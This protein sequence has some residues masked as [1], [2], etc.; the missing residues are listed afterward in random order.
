MKKVMIALLALAV[1]FSFAACDNSSGTPDSTSKEIARIYQAAT[2]DV[3][4]LVGQVA[5][6]DDF[7]VMVEYTD[8]TSER[9]ASSNLT[10]AVDGTAADTQLK[11]DSTLAVSYNL[12]PAGAQAT[13][14]LSVTILPV[15]S[16]KVVFNGGSYDSYYEK[17][18]GSV[19]YNGSDATTANDIFH[20]SQYTV[21]AVYDTDKEYVLSSDEYVVTALT[22]T[23]ANVAN[24]TATIKL[25]LNKDGKAD[26]NES[27][28]PYNTVS[29]TAG[30][31][32]ILA[33]TLSGINATL[34]EGKELIAGAVA[35]S[36]DVKGL[37]TVTGN[38]A[39]G[40]VKALSTEVTAVAFD[41][42]NFTQTSTEKD[43][44]PTT[45][46]VK[47]NFTVT[48]LASVQT[49][50]FPVIA[51]YVKSFTVTP[52]GGV[53]AG[54]SITNALTVK[55]TWAASKTSDKS[56]ETKLTIVASPS[57]MPSTTVVGSKIPV[58]VSIQ[59]QDVA[60][61][62]IFVE[63]VAASAGQGAGGEEA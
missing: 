45:G 11:A 20:K 28:E 62:T 25:D 23:T 9:V 35:E 7:T 13:T 10:L 60:A 22:D 8:G 19:S 50:E 56:E 39:S 3:T 17:V 44:Y 5:N 40:A 6:L 15:T 32:V 49:K 53:Q 4:Y 42:A 38:Y 48:G 36:A 41:T 54:A 55:P 21:T 63:C 57:T 27:S 43:S 33:D 61:Q 26:F 2:D 18:V 14:D 29:G 58:T 12:A 1:L 37:F 34:V 46:N 52:A 30:N 24:A 51:N 31:I 47:V 59:G 16:I